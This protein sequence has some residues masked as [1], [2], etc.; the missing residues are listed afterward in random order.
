MRNMSMEEFKNATEGKSIEDFV[1]K[2]KEMPIYGV[3]EKAV[4]DKE[5]DD[6]E[7]LLQMS[8][9]LFSMAD[10]ELSAMMMSVSTE[11]LFAMVDQR[12]RNEILSESEEQNAD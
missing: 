2:V 1:Q 4:K 8:L 3:Y 7:K 12:L 6:T 9:M 10:N 5:K 11:L